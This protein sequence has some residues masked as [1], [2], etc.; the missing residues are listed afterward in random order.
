LPGEFGLVGGLGQ[1]LVEETRGAAAGEG[2][3]ETA[4]FLNGVTGDLGPQVGG[5]LG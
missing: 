1:V 2:D 3:D 4:A 5:R